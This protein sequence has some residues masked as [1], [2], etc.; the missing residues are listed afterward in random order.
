MLRTRVIPA[1]LIDGQGLVKTVKFKKPQYIGDASN[2]CRI[3]NQME[4]DEL[5]LFD[6][7]ASSN[8]KSI[9]FKMI[10]KIVSECFMPICYGGG[11]KSIDDFKTLFRI[12]VE[13]VSVSSLMFE[14]KDVIQS[15]IK[16]FGSQSIV[17]VLDVKSS[18]F[19]K[20]KQIYIYNGK[21]K[22][23]MPIEEAVELIKEIGFGELIVNSIDR[24][25]TWTGFDCELV[26]YF[27]ERLDIPVVALGGAG[28]KEDI[29]HAVYEG[30]A[31]AVAL[32]SMA[33]F[34]SK[35]MGVLIKFPKL[36]EIK[37]ILE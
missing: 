18:R 2:S 6:I 16:I 34:Q 22:I 33:V 15:A 7:K 19:L 32:G 31:S 23:Q 14:N 9:Q 28:S 27:S 20:K 37:K 8:K 21:K 30:H 10:E 3:Y 1:L 35:G 29:R 36:N 17:G 25:G 5:M 24:E 26:R 13:K 12:G 11:V 4:V